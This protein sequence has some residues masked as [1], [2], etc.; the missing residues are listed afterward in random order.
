MCSDLST[1]QFLLTN[2]FYFA[3][4]RGRRRRRSVRSIPGLTKGYY[5]CPNDNCGRSYKAKG[6]LLTHLKY[7]CG[8]APRFMCSYCG[9]TTSFRSNLRRHL[10]QRHPG[11]EIQIVDIV[12]MR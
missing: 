5:F 3:G 10:N 4:L 6:T 9:F 12:K 7:E 2:K 8:Q 11:K 1:N